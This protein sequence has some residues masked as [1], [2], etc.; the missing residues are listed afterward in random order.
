MKTPTEDYD[1]LKRRTLARLAEGKAAESK[2][3]ARVERRRRRLRRLSFGLL[4]RDAA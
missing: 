4:G 3:R 1:E 2:W